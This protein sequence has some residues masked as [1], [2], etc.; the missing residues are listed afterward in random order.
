M[1]STKDWTEIAGCR[2]SPPVTGIQSWKGA[3]AA[4]ERHYL[5]NCKQASLLPKTSWGSGESSSAWEGALVVHPENQ[6]A[7]IGVVISRS[8]HAHQTPHHLS[9]SDLGRAQNTGPTESVPLRTTRVHEPEQLRPG[10]C[11]QPRAGLARFPAEQPRAWAVWARIAHTPWVGAGPM[12]LRH[13]KHTP[14]LFVCSIPPSSQRDWTSEP[15]KVSTTAPF[16]SGRKSDTE[17]TSKQKKLKQR[18]PPW[19]WQVQYIKTL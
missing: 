16:V 4:P 13:C 19:K 7:G 18:E 5:P 8:D 17:E 3:I 2:P 1:Y 15:K 12:W 6:A 14:V 11:M 9:C 10:R